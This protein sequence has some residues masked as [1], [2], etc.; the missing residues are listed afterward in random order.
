MIFFWFFYYL[1]LIFICFSLSK[2]IQKKNIKYFLIPFIFG[3]FGSLWYV[4]PG[5]N[6]IAPIISILFLELSILESNGINRLLR[7]ALS[8]ILFLEFISLISYFIRKRFSKS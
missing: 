3:V 6:E 5:K 4:E 7:P 8:F 1:V 2:L